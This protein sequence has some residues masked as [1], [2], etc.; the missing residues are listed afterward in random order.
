V[1]RARETGLVEIGIHDLRAFTKDKHRTVDDRPFGG[2]E[3]MVLKPEPIFECLESFGTVA[4]REARLSPGAK[5]SVICFRRRAQARS[6][7]SGGTL[8]AGP[9]GVDLRT[10]RRRRRTHQ[11]AP[12]GSRSFDRRLCVE[13][14]RTGRSGDCGYDYAADSGRGGQPEFDAAESFTERLRDRRSWLAT[15]RVRRAFPADCSIIRIT[16]G[17]RSIA[18]W[19]CRKC[20]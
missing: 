4:S 8:G 3:G 14:R 17:R 11:R 2:G 16:R 12:G 19:R 10:L 15:G 9:C 18:A 7:S 5:Q 20:W 13:R 6:D 1:R